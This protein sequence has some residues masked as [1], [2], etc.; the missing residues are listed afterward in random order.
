M[1]LPAPDAP[2]LQIGRRAAARARVHLPVTL[3]T[4]NGG[5]PAMLENISGGGA[6]VG[7]NET[8]RPGS[9]AFLV[10]A[11]LELFCSV[12]WTHNSRCGLAFE[13]P[14]ADATL[15][16]IRRYSDQ[17]VAEVRSQAMECAG[18]RTGAFL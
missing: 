12:V 6:R 18:L 10:F 3:L 17:Y 14:V 2:E 5:I 13:D 4:P 8:P 9:T 16:A 15:I 1:T 7:L 11:G